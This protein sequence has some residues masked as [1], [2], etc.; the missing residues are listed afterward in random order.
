MTLD[1]TLG[2]SAS[3]PGKLLIAGEYA[4]L[5]GAP[6][7][8]MAINR[9]A[10]A[11]LGARAREIT[12]LHLAIGSELGLGRDQ[13]EALVLDSRGFFEEDRKQGLGSSAA[14]SVAASA[15]LA[16]GDVF[17]TALAIH[18]RFQSG[19]GSG[20]DVAASTYGGVLAYRP[21]KTPLRVELPQDLCWQAF[22][23]GRPASS[24]DAIGRWHN[25]RGRKAAL[26]DAAGTVAASVGDSAGEFIASISQFQARLLELDRTCSLAIS[27]PAQAALEAEARRTGERFGAALVYKQSGAG[28]GDTSLALSSDYTALGAFTRIAVQSGLQPLD[29]SIDMQ[30][31][32]RD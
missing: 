29:L 18:R 23:T 19:L 31:V 15:L 28:G 17:D 24:S 9:R 2:T 32:K 12:P 4:V 30:G 11:S 26:V 21:G 5:E 3:A 13:L 22:D 25:A 8:V 16:S 6:A 10:R 1:E 27:S 14:L 20:F 7:L